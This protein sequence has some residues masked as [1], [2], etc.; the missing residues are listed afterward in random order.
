[1]ASSRIWLHVFVGGTTVDC[2]SA[3]RNLDDLDFRYSPYFRNTNPCNHSLS[4]NLCLYIY[5]CVYVCMGQVRSSHWVPQNFDLKIGVP[6]WVFKKM[7]PHLRYSS[8]VWHEL[9]QLRDFG[10][11]FHLPVLNVG[12]FRDHS[13]NNHP[14]NPQ[15]PIQQ[16]YV[17]RTIPTF[18]MAT[19]YSLQVMVIFLVIWIPDFTR[20]F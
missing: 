16:P 10:F 14:S 5:V 15:Q 2:T 1:M 12:N 7:T 13:S 17:K 11:K 4:R 6:S 20:R 9:C 8:L 18:M 3:S 19:I